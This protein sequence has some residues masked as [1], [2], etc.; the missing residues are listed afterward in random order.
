MQTLTLRNGIQMPILGYGVYR[1]SPEETEQCVLD[2]GRS[3][4][5]SHQDPAIVEWFG[6]KVEERKKQGHHPASE[7]KA[8]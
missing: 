8:W 4:F 5:F 2:K 6:Q 3:A 1:V 7:K